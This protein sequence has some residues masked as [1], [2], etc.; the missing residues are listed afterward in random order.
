MTGAMAAKPENA[1]GECRVKAYGAKG[2]GVAL[3]TVA[4]N[5]AVQDCKDK[6]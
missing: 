1:S 3:D 5:A 4:I 6:C 2:D